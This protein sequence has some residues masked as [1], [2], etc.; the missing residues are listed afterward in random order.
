MGSAARAEFEDKYTARANYRILLD[1]YQEA[2]DTNATGKARRTQPL[3]PT[4][5]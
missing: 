1:I 5:K 3:A 4:L 2:L